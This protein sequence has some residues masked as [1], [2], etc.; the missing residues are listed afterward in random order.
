MEKFS[1][2]ILAAGKGTRMNLG[3]NKIFYQLNEGITILEKSLKAF[4]DIDKIEQIIIVVSEKDKDQAKQLLKEYH[5]IQYVIGGEKRHDSVFAGLKEVRQS[6]VLI[7]DAARCFITR[8]QIDNII[9]ATI[10]HLAVTL[11]YPIKDT[12]HLVNDDNMVIETVDRDYAYLAQTPQGFLTPI[13]IE[14]YHNFNQSVNPINITD[15]VMI[16]N[17]YTDFQVKVIESNASNYKITFK[18]DLE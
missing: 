7:H 6:Y 14:A 16:V 18:E 13:I 11:A 8:E 4:Y 1:L 10:E 17:T 3:Y 15:D 12:I 9:N 2:I 5:N